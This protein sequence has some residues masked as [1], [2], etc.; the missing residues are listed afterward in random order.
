ML[1]VRLILC[2]HRTTKAGTFVNPFAPGFSKPYVPETTF[3]LGRF[4]SVPQVTLPDLNDDEL[5]LIPDRETEEALGIIE[6]PSVL[7][8]GDDSGNLQFLYKG[9]IDLGSIKLGEGLDI[10]AAPVARTIITPKTPF[11]PVNY[12]VELLVLASVP[13]QA[14]A[15]THNSLAP[16]VM[17]LAASAP[18]ASSVVQFSIRVPHLP[19]SELSMLERASTSVRALLSHAYE[20]FDEARKG[21]EEVRGLGKKWLDRL[22]EEPDPVLPELQLLT[23]LLT[24]R[25]FNNNMHEYFASKNTERVRPECDVLHSSSPTDVKALQN[26][27]T[28]ETNHLKAAARIRDT[29]FQH[30][31][32]VYERLTLW[33][34]QMRGWALW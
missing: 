6:H 7:A 17:P 9:A 4:P 28:W 14:A 30:L 22:K 19:S 21:W 34:T 10:I 27:E 20:A 18:G 32:P 5:D 11:K 25:P 31:N 33:L 8:L 16:H 12:S 1:K 13:H 29:A 26:L 15:T 24:G 2:S 3:A 23:L